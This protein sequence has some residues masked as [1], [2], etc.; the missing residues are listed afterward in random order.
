MSPLFLLRSVPLLLLG[1]CLC[2]ALTEKEKPNHFRAGAAVVDIAPQKFPVRVNGMFTERMADKV[3]DPLTARALALDDGTT[4]LVMCV[5]DTCMM[6]RDLIDAAKKLASE[7]TGL[8]TDRMMV[9]ATHTHSAPAAMGCLGSRVDPDYAAMLPGKVAQAIIAAVQNLQPARAGWTAFDD[10]DHTHNRRWIRRP[11]RLLNDPFG[12]P[13]VRANMHPGH[14]S[15]DV[16]GPSGPVDPQ[17]SLLAVETADGQPLALLANYSMH[18]YESPLLSS[19]YFGR[20]NAHLAQMLGAGEKF[21]GIMS[22]GTS[23]DLMWMDYGAPRQQIGYD[24]YA[25]EIATRV[26]AA[27]K[28]IEWKTNVPLAMAESTLALN[29]RVPDEARLKWAQEMEAKLGDKLPQ[30][31]AEIYA[32]EATM[33]HER[34]KTELKLQALR[35]GDFGITALPNE[36]FCLTGLKLK[37]RSPFALTMNIELANGADGYIPPPEQHALG[38]YTTWPARTAGLEV[39]AEPK[40]TEA[41]TALLEKVSGKKR[42]AEQPAETD[43]AKAVTAGKPVA[44]WRMEE[45]DAGTA[46]DRTGKHDALIEPGV[47]VYLPGMGMTEMPHAPSP[48]RA[49]HFA[50][51]R[52]KSQVKLGDNYSVAFWLWNT[53]PADSRLV[54]GYAFSRGADGDKLHGEHLGIGGTYKAEAQ[55]RLIL[56]N[57]NAADQ[58]LTGKTKLAL[59]DWHHVVLVREG[60]K[61]RV[62]LNGKPV[63]DLEG[64]LPVV[65][66]SDDVFIGGRSDNLFNWEGKLDEVALFDRAMPPTEVNQLYQSAGPANR[67]VGFQPTSNAGGQDVPATDFPP[68]SPEEGLKSIHVPDGFKVELVACEPQVIDPV[69]IDWDLAGRLW[70]V[71]MADYPSGMDNKEKP[72]GRV[73]VLEDVDGDGKYEK[74][75]LFAD[76]LNFPTGLLTWRDGV[77]VTAAPDVLFLKDTNGDGKADSTEKLISGLSEGNQQLR[78]NGL[79]CGL[80]NRVYCAAGGHHGGHGANTVLRSHRDKVDVKLG[81]RDFSFDPDTGDVRAESGPSQFGRNRDDAGHWFGTQNS[82]ALWQYVMPDHYLKRNPHVPAPD[83]THLIVTPLNAPVYPLSPPE[84]RFHSF[85]NA[86]HFTSACS[87]M[88]Y[89]DELLWPRRDNELDAFTCEPFHNLVQHNILVEDGVTYKAKRAPGEEK[90]DFFASTDRWCRPVMTRTGP[91]G[92]LWV[93]DMYRYMIEHPAWLPENGRAELLPHYRLGDDKGRIY[94]VFRADKPPRKVKPLDKLKPVELVAALDSPNEWQRD[95]SHMA[96]VWRA[97]ERN[98]TRPAKKSAE[99]PAPPQQERPKGARQQS[100]GPARNERSPGDASQQN[101]KPQRG[102]TTTVA[103]RDS[104]PALSGLVISS[105]PNPGLTPRA[106]LPRP[107]GA[108]AGDMRLHNLSGFV[109]TDE[110][111]LEPTEAALIAALQNASHLTRLQAMCVLD[112]RRAFPPALVFDSLR[113]KHAVIREHALRLAMSGHNPAVVGEAVKLAEDQSARIR[114]Q[115]AFSLGAW[116]KE[117]HPFY[118]LAG[119]ALARLAIRDYSDPWMRAAVMSSAVPHC[120]ALCEG[121][122]A[123]GGEAFAAYADDLTTLALALDDRDSLAAMLRPALTAQEGRYTAAQL[124]SFSRLLGSLEKK[125]RTRA[126]L[127]ERKD[128]KDQKDELTKV[129]ESAGASFAFAGKILADATTSPEFRAA[130]AGLLVRE[131]ATRRAAMK[132]LPGWL[133]PGSDHALQLAAVRTLAST[134]EPAVPAMLLH[135]F[136]SLTPETRSAIVEALLSREAWAIALLEHGKSNPAVA[137]DATQRARLTQHSSQK[138]R[139]LAAAV[140]KSESSRKEVLDHFR[141]ALQLKGDAARGKIV[142]S[143]RCI[144]C[145]KLDN[146]GIDIGPDLK[147]VVGHPPEKILTNIIDPSLDVQ[148][149]FFAFQAKLKDGSELY[150]L[151][152]SETGNSVT[153]KLTDGSSKL[154]LRSDL[155]DLKTAGQSLMPPGLET[156]MTTQEM[157]DLIQ[158]LQAPGNKAAGQ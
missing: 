44:F 63:P 153:F 36:V 114:L 155:A 96:L 129:L 59:K 112:G 3:V 131:E 88:I 34:Q 130:A 133:S 23:G 46:F 57:G 65:I 81:S 109:Q 45:M 7:A 121:I 137:L 13:N 43:Y 111:G 77:I 99:D 24:A 105:R 150:G 19:D 4:R 152:T 38:G 87:G 11:D 107:V 113:D 64:E 149:G 35:I 74:S 54:T 120:R 116:T 108:D 68:L 104:H 128:A 53:L 2:F 75:T 14:Q 126:A 115:L 136:P 100:P 91:V 103:G 158:F 50:G 82:R 138:V 146:T 147:S 67:S 98:E 55:G 135:D 73:R 119:T 154:V 25:K 140:L 101:F 85:E 47:A 84:K 125:G 40:I 102:G 142:F 39:Q 17:L 134:T 51:G 123:A 139:E 49:F 28:K 1:V 41:L 95:K 132:I 118:A 70:V 18:Y 30:S 22:Q 122:A 58:L 6:P 94:R 143:T 21:V 151:V 16:T 27:C 97:D 20:F 10:W 90:H 110:A 31:Q 69:A 29:F 37:A 48:G 76:G 9:S 56:F 156:G 66:K 62:H 92:A 83:P 127:A 141:T 52:M 71:E 106:V 60:A 42:R 145:H 15:P 124:G 61:V 5:V 72:G 148:P 157:A 78:A 33:L 32:L 8:P 144:A 117:E 89:R 86:N 93:V 79:R 12:V 26:A 80:D